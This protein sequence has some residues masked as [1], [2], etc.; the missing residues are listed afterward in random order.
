M[1]KL[2]ISKEAAEWYE[3]EYD[4]NAPTSLRIY[5][6]YGGVG[7]LIPGFSIGLNLEEAKKTDIYVDSSVSQIHFFIVE[8]DA[9]Y[10]ENHHLHIDFDQELIEPKFIYTKKN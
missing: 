5:V 7:G 9:W 4:I 3:H 8:S 2:S 6:R 10:F 1:M